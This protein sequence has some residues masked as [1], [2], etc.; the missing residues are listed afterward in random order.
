MMK[1]YCN[2]CTVDRDLIKAELLGAM[3]KKGE[4]NEYAIPT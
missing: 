4:Q 3:K 2:D 1:L